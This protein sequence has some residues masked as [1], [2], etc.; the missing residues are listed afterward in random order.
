M[1]NINKIISIV[2][3]T[4]GMLHNENLVI[5]QENIQYL[6]AKMSTCLSKYNTKEDYIEN[7]LQFLYTLEEYLDE[8]L[9]AE[10][11][12]NELLVAC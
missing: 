12:K 10:Q 2:K 5:A 4:I 3:E 1:R 6:D 9:E 8:C 7:A 11:L